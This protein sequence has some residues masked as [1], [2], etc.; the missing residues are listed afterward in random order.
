MGTCVSAPDSGAAVTDA[1]CA[2]C[3]SG[4]QYWPCD[5]PYYQWNLCLCTST[6]ATQTTPASAST[7][8]SILTTP[9]PTATPV[10][11]APSDSTP[12][13]TCTALS[14]NIYGLTDESCMPC[15][16]GQEH[17]PCDSAVYTWNLCICSASLAQHGTVSTARRQRLRSQQYA[18]PSGTAF[19]QTLNE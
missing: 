4:Q 3:A 14:N 15:A 2:Q 16:N 5:S 7:S 6:P 18:V 1:T 8:A 10:P 13:Q 9:A 19:V 17:Y 11:N 12:G